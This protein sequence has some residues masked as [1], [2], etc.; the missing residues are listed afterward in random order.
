MNILDL[1]Y[2]LFLF[3]SKLF[4]ICLNLTEDGVVAGRCCDQSLS[5]CRH[6][7]ALVDA[8]VL[9]DDVVHYHW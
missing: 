8:L 4:L 2:S 7:A 9:G 3:M 1:H 6:D 5:S